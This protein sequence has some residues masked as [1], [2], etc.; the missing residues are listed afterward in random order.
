VGAPEKYTL[1]LP[2]GSVL[3]QSDV[4]AFA[5]FARER[6]LTNDEAQAALAEHDAALRAQ[7]DRFLT[8]LKAHAEVGGD[9]LAVSQQRANAVLDKFLPA[10]SPEGKVLRAGLAKSGYGNWTP[11][12]LLLDRIGKAMGED[13]P[14]KAGAGA[15]ARSTEK[16]S[17]ADV[18][19][20]STA[21]KQA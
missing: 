8:D 13:L 12:V 11:L 4:D 10:E 3:E 21:P 5:T 15:G 14:I 7:S 6:N 9:H 17:T 19:F 18:L 20:P 16:K 1:A 2:A